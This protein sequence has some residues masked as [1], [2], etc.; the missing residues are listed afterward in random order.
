M[1]HQPLTPNQVEAATRPLLGGAAAARLLEQKHRNQVFAVGEEAIFKAYLRD[2]AARQARKVAALRFLEGRGLPVARRLGHG[3]LPT[4]VPW[5]LESR[6]VV[7]H[8]R[9]TR[10]ALDTPQ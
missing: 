1:G 2:G 4:G 7:G 5:T 10:A 8:R 6:V 3:V 9:P